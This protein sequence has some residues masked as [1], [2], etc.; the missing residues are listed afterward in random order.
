MTLMIELPEALVHEFQ[1]RQ[2][3]ESDIKKVIL[4]TL[5]I[6]LN[7]TNSHNGRRFSES[8]VPFV[9]SLISRNRELFETLAKT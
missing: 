1:D 4:A 6:W 8:A 2:V 3:S 9:R 7:A 5:E